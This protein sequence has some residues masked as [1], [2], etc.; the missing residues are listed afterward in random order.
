MG[1]LAFAGNAP[2]GGNPHPERKARRMANHG[3]DAIHPRTEPS[4][5]LVEAARDQPLTAHPSFTLGVAT[6]WWREVRSFYRQRSRIIAALATPLLFWL[7]LGSG[8]GS[9]LQAPGASKAGYFEFFFPG[10]VA[11]VVLFTAI[12]ANISVIEDRREGFLLS[13]LVAPVPRLALVLGKVFG[14]TTV[15]LLQGLL[16]LPLAPMLG[17]SIHA[18]R[19]PALVAMIFLLA[20]GLTCLGFCFAWQLNS[21]SA[22]HSVMNTILMPM[23]LLSGSLFPVTGASTWVRWVMFVNPLTYGVSGLR[24]LLYEGGM[25]HG[26]SLLVCW[27][28]T[29]GFSIVSLVTAAVLAASR[30]AGN[31]S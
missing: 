29:I 6:L 3:F 19:I 26:P 13:V 1:L 12:F 22:F 2:W 20:F 30:S 14:A 15:G 27:L 31:V 9:S 7:V 18:S 10:T 23:W 17:L 16:L 28:V 11:L 24:H 25:A 5:V 21:V 8:F 4:G